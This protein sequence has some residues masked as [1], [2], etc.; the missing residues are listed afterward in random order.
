MKIRHLLNALVLSLIA[1][2][3]GAACV[4]PYTNAYECLGVARTSTWGMKTIGYQISQLRSEYATEIA[5]TANTVVVGY[6]PNNPSSI[7]PIVAKLGPDLKII[8]VINSIFT[9]PATEADRSDLFI[10]SQLNTLASLLAGKTA[11]IAYLG[12]DES[13]WRRQWKACSAVG[14]PF[15]QCLRNGADPSINA[16]VVAN[17]E[18]WSARVHDFFRGVSMFYNE[19]GAFIRPAFMLPKNYDSYSFDCYGNFDSC[20]YV[21]QSIPALLDTLRTKVLALNASYPAYRRLALIAETTAGYN[22]WALRPGAGYGY[23]YDALSPYNPAIANG[24]GNDNSL[25][26]LIQRY[27]ALAASDRMVTTMVGFVWDNLYEG[28]MTWLGLRGMPLS[29]AYM[30]DYARGITGKPAPNLTTPPTIDFA[31]TQPMSVNNG[32]SIWAWAAY[33]ATRCRSVSDP[34]PAL[35]NLPAN[36]AFWLPP[37]LA[38]RSFDYTLEC[39]GSYGTTQKTIR[40]TVDSAPVNK[41]PIPVN[42]TINPSS[43]R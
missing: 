32:G 31:V 7:A 2:G 13:L 5:A 29:R 42:C 43:C 23:V 27:T 28:D 11:Y 12:F 34:D 21:N 8:I 24:S 22:R 10:T 9:D 36:G 37:E 20:P 33:N 4:A 25:R 1:K 15:D 14:T 19:S 16:S 6:D 26:S 39:T 3:A 17:L 35:Q 41:T 40:Y 38:S 18:R 30:E